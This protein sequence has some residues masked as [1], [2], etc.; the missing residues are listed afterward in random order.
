MIDRRKIP[1]NQ[2]IREQHF[3]DKA[4][5]VHGT[6]YDYA[7]MKY[8]NDKSDIIIKCNTHGAFIQTPN[9]H[10]RGQGCRLCGEKLAAEKIRKSAET[11]FEEVTKIHNNRYDYSKSNY[12]YARDKITIICP[13]HGEFLQTA[14]AHLNGRSGCPKCG[15]WISKM[16]TDWLDSLSVPDKYR[17]KILFID[18]KKI[19]VDAYDP[20]INTVYEF[21]G[22]YW[23]GNPMKYQADG[24]NAKNKKT[25]GELFE[26][27]QLKRK[28]IIDAGYI[29][30][31]KWETE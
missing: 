26:E 7:D 4:N 15:N 17:Q 25:F 11:Y 8:V 19:R 14:S 21:W 6:R 12:T 9:N 28:I 22:D 29:L 13:K 18:N 1:K 16:E 5:V 31:E 27:T 30:I 23:H 24:I 20:D 2:Q 3:L 10:L